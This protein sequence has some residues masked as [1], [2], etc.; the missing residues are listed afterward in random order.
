MLAARLS[1][2]RCEAAF[3]GEAIPKGRISMKTRLLRSAHKGEIR[4]FSAKG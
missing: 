3:D 1:Q 4:G 2:G